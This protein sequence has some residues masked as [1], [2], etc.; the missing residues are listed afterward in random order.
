M[1]Q[2]IPGLVMLGFAVTAL[3]LVTGAAYFAWRDTFG[4]PAAGPPPVPAH[5][6]EA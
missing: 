2:T 5:H 1:I 6:L 3:V 4:D